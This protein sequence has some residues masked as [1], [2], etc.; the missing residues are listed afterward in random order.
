MSD[1][2]EAL[3]RLAERVGILPEYLNQ[4]GET[5]HTPDATR[6]AILAAMGLEAATPAA[7]RASLEELESRAEARLLPPVKVHPRGDPDAML[8]ELR[9]PAGHPA[10][11]AWEATLTLED[12]T[13]R[14]VEGRAAAADGRARVQ[15]RGRLPLGYHMLR[16][17]ART[18][19][20]EREAE[21][22]V[23]VV[24]RAG[25][26]VRGVFGVVANLYTVPGAGDWGVG[27]FSTL[28]RLMEWTASEGG[29]FVGVNPLHAI[30][31][32]GW[33]VSPYSPV[34]RLFRNPL[35]LDPAA[36]PGAS[37]EARELLRSPGVSAERSALRDSSSVE[38]ERVMALKRRLLETIHAGLQPGEGYAGYVREQG[39]ELDRFA[40]F[41]A[42]AD[43]FGQ[44]D[45]REWPEPYRSPERHEV[46]AFRASHPREVDLH[47]WMQYELDRQ[48]ADAAERGR[49]AGLRVGLYQ[50]LAIGS[51]PGGSDVW[52]NP[53]LFL[54]RVSVG[55][56][57]DDLGPTGQNWGLPPIDPRALR[58]D[59][60]RFWI[61]LLRASFR[62]AGA[63]RIDHVLGLFRQF[64]I[65]D[66]FSGSDGAYVRFPA[67]DL[68]GILLLEARRHRAVVVGEDLGTVPPEVPPALRGRRILSS[69]VFYFE[70]EGE[71]YRPASEYEFA[72]LATAN[73]H[74]LPP[75]AGFWTGRDLELRQAAGAIPSDEAL[76]WE[77]GVRARAKRAILER[78]AAEG[79]LPSAE[80]P[81][82]PAALRGAIHA[83]LCS[84]PAA[85]VGLSL[86]DLVGERDPVNL[87]G[88]APDRHLSWTRKLGMPVESLADDAS[89][90]AALRCGRGR[91]RRR[92]KE[93][94]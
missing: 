76:E 93:G 38:Y 74:D 90:R 86:D 72:A 6:V 84:T 3:H 57:P 11:I 25:R 23:I 91:P 22:R 59:Q 4:M 85:M 89:V 31:N 54:Q 26:E 30:R 24:P 45:W 65:P 13:A 68:L 12:G 14:R 70:R 53:H 39:E 46:A 2:A 8:R 43:H 35:Y 19:S 81:A 79:A 37:P 27:D 75:I 67:D 7:A 41:G 69:R 28:A 9:L 48:L 71:R 33:D 29:D 47:R 34:S 17:T 87:P 92:R 56:P 10:E 51:A 73:T 44:A 1:E 60:Y 94:R 15:L 78:L 80:E 16:M 62:H 5:R 21:Q 20:S 42:L 63:L 66:G 40:T 58:E 55:A 83:F 18:G 50:D 82:D 88:I 64:W 32:R 61:E 77:R 49:R 36:I 52:A